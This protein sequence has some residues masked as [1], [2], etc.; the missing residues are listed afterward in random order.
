MQSLPDYLQGLTATPVNVVSFGADT[1]GR[2]N[3]T[4]AVVKSIEATNGAV[5][6]PGTFW[7]DP[8]TISTEGCLIVLSPGTTLY[9][10]SLGQSV[11]GITGT[12]NNLYILGR[13]TLK[14]P[15][16][17]NNMVYVADECGLYMVG[18]SKD[19]RL[20]GLYAPDVTLRN[21]GGYGLYAKFVDNI[22]VDSAKAFYC[23]Y[24]GLTFFSCDTG[25]ARYVECGDIG[26]GTG[27][28]APDFINN[29]YGLSLSHINSDYASN[30]FCKGWQ[31]GGI[32]YNVDW[33]GVDCHGAEDCMFFPIWT[34]NCRSGVAIA[35]SSGASINYAGHDNILDNFV[36]DARKRDGSAGDN[37]N[38]G[39]GYAIT[40]T[41]S[42]TGAQKRVVIG[43][44]TIYGYGRTTSGGTVY[45]SP[46]YAQNV[47]NLVFSGGLILEQWGGNAINI[48][49]SN[50]Q[51]NGVTFG[52]MYQADSAAVCFY[53]DGGSTGSYTQSFVGNSVL[54]TTYPPGY[55]LR[56]YSS[57]RPYLTGNN[58]GATS[59]GTL[60]HP[61]GAGFFSG[62]DGLPVLQVDLGGGGGS[63]TLDMSLVNN[64]AQFPRVWVQLTAS[65]P[66]SVTDISNYTAG[67]TFIFTINAGSSTI[68]FTR[69][70]MVLPSSAVWSGTARSTMTYLM[71][72]GATRGLGLAQTTNG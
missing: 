22:D 56:S 14:G 28:T 58:T 68:T 23:G 3:S 38:A 72:G 63:T 30:P 21:F 65:A 29:M 36:I 34:Y 62:T 49:L 5:F 35:G 51:A 15:Q 59:A 1:T 50:V 17:P 67:Q 37:Q 46:I 4:K 33:Q 20:S 52:E 41:A 66:I 10:K 6:P 53:N 24:G 57:K 9:F 19:E 69:A 43:K 40:V 25:L 54:A 12:A 47:D 42:G 26:P 44:G 2:R 31:V 48:S 27:G 32:F 61:N 8:I 16:D 39:N 60:I 11:K 55:F 13:G 45:A 7:L 71:T 70:N 64:L 18:T